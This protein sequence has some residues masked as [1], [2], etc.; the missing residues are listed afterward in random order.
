VVFLEKFKRFTADLSMHIKLA[1]LQQFAIAL[2]ECD[3]D[4]FSEEFNAAFDYCLENFEIYFFDPSRLLDLIKNLE[5]YGFYEIRSSCVEKIKQL[6]D[7]FDDLLEEAERNPHLYS[8]HLEALKEF[9]HHHRNLMEQLELKSRNTPKRQ[10]E[11]L[12]GIREA[13]SAV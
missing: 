4:F 11:I 12:R 9:Q 3:E 2:I 6:S 10:L 8:S 7:K 1:A 5:Q 13:K